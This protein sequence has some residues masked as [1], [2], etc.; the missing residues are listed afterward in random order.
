MSAAASKR[1]ILAM[2]RTNDPTG[3]PVDES[4]LEPL[5][6]TDGL[7]RETFADDE[8][9]SVEAWLRR[10]VQREREEMRARSV[11]AFNN[12]N[13]HRL[14]IIGLVGCVVADTALVDG[15]VR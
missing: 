11:T 4:K 14:K 9:Q 2:A 15:T 13:S 3:S 8:R 10:I 7:T 1:I 6:T 12:W 5:F